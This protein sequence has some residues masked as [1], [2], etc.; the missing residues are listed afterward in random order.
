MILF[1]DRLKGYSHRLMLYHGHNITNAGLISATAANP[2]NTGMEV[3]LDLSFRAALPA[4]NERGA[5]IQAIQVGLS[6]RFLYS[7]V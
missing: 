5:A 4:S 7:R 2:E 1:M 6:C 3:S